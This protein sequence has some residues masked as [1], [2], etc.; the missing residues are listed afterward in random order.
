MSLLLEFHIF[1]CIWNSTLSTGTKVF[2]WLPRDISDIL[3]G[4]KVNRQDSMDQNL[5]SLI[6]VSILF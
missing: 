6:E 1:S 5:N 2:Q 4:L 3:E